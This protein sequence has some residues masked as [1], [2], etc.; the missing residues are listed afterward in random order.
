[1]PRGTS[2]FSSEVTAR[3]GEPQAEKLVLMS[4]AVQTETS[5]MLKGHP[6]T[7]IV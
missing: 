2:G 3:R 1:M 5:G 7:K 4:A 6:R